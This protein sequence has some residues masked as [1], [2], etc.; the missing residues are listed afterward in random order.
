MRRLTH[1]R[2]FL[3]KAQFETGRF[4]MAFRTLTAAPIPMYE[5]ETFPSATCI[6][7]ALVLA[8]RAID[9]HK[10]DRAE[11]FLD[12]ITP[13]ELDRL[14]GYRKLM[15]LKP[16]RQYLAGLLAFRRGRADQAREIWTELVDETLAR[17]PRSGNKL[18]HW[19]DWWSPPK[20]EVM[21]VRGL[22]A[23]NL[24]DPPRTRAVMKRLARQGKRSADYWFHRSESTLMWQALTAELE[25]DF[26]SARKLLKKATAAGP[27]TLQAQRHLEAVSA[28]RRWLAP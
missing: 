15:S 13:E 10:F 27:D 17:Q 21:Y 12:A 25:G 18:P 11:T 5:G 2:K 26:T 19:S 8:T 3:G 6:E 16:R 14:Y 24:G 9:A 28:N 22:A 20:H 23:I 1:I 4:S 7:T